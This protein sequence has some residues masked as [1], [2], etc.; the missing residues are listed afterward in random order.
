MVNVFKKLS[1]LFLDD[2]EPS[3]IGKETYTEKRNRCLGRYWQHIPG[4]VLLI[5]KSE[6]HNVTESGL[7]MVISVI[8][9]NHT[10]SKTH[11]C[12]LNVCSLGVT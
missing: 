12:N 3:T 11:Q 9:S 4:L 6:V 5:E 7:Q 2:G 10:E 8:K 1:N